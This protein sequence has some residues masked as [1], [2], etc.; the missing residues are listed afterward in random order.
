VHNKKGEGRD[1]NLTKAN[2]N[3]EKLISWHLS[4]AWL[5]YMV[6]IEFLE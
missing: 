2:T 1:T 6:K 5:D 3:I 4:V